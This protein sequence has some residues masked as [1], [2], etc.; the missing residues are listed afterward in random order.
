MSEKQSSFGFCR[1]THAFL[2]V[3]SVQLLTT[4]LSRLIASKANLLFEMRFQHTF[5]VWMGFRIN[6]LKRGFGPKRGFSQS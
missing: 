6:S 5:D 1:K 2:F 3:M 4:L